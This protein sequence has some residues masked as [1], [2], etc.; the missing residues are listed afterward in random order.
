MPRGCRWC[1]D[2]S[3]Y[4][5]YYG[6]MAITQKLCTQCGHKW[7]PRTPKRPVLCPNK[8]CHSTRWDEHVQ[9]DAG[10]RTMA[11]AK[12]YP[13]R[14]EAHK[15]VAAALKAGYLTRPNICERCSSKT[16]TVAHHANYMEPLRVE[17]LCDKCHRK[18]HENEKRGTTV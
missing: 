2:K 12:K 5:T 10:R 6:C 4:G 17:W 18:H 16:Y 1:I 14:K 13:E 11:W 8:S 9:T 7:F 15:R 3:Y